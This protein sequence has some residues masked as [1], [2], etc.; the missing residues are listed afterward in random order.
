MHRKITGVDILISVGENIAN[1]NGYIE[2]NASASYLWDSMKEA[3]TLNELSDLLVEKFKITKDQA[4]N[5]VKE[6]LELLLEH[7]MVEVTRQ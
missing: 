1:F 6:F 5:D 4:M 3:H 7:Q 2:M